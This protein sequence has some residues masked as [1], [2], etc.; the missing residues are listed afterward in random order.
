MTSLFWVLTSRILVGRYQRNG[1]KILSLMR[2]R[3]ISRHTQDSATEIYIGQTYILTAELKS[4]I[5][6]FERIKIVYDSQED[7]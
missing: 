3:R 4:V 7:R 1:D 5:P 6:V 2:D